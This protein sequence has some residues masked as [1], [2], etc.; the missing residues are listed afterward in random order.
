M[1]F[2]WIEDSSWDKSDA[3]NHGVTVDCKVRSR[4]GHVLRLIM[5]QDPLN[6]KVYEFLANEPDLPPGIIAELYRRRWEAEKVFD[7][8]KNKLGQ[9]KAWATTLVAKES[10]ALLIAITHNLLLRY[11]QDLEERHDVQN[12]AEDQRRSKRLESAERAC[13][14]IGWP[15]SSLVLAARRAT[16]RSVKFI[17]WLR[18]AIRER[19]AE[20]AAVARLK[21]LYAVL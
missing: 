20:A 9:K 12:T 14:E 21:Q 3:R 6:G 1:V 18:Y 17:R 4:E 16:Q 19:L 11:E 15:I 5:Y 7:E 8:V 13:T 10:Q 2:E